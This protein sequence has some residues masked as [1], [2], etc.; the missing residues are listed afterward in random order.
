MKSK[1]KTLFPSV[2]IFF[3]AM[4][5][6]SLGDEVDDSRVVLHLDLDCFCESLISSVSLGGKARRE[7]RGGEERQSER[8]RKKKESQIGNARFVRPLQPLSVC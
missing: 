1:E 7:R 5:S 8:A 3:S 2:E 6:S 4:A